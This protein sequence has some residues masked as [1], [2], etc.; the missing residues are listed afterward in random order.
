MCLGFDKHFDIDEYLKCCICIEFNIDDLVIACDEIVNTSETVLINS[1][2]KNATY[3][4]R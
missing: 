3:E 2:D 1:N 4:L